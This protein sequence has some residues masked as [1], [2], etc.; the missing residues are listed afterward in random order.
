MSLARIVGGALLGAA[1]CVAA[2]ARP[3]P[4]GAAEGL[5]QV[6][7]AQ[8]ISATAGGFQQSLAEGS[9]FGWAVDALGDFDGDGAVEIA[10]GAHFAPETAP[11]TGSLWLLELRADGTVG[12]AEKI[13][14]RSPEF[15]GPITQDD[16][17]GISLAALGD[18]DGD[19]GVELAVGAPGDDDGG[20]NAGAIYIL[21]FNEAGELH[22]RSKISPR[23]LWARQAPWRWLLPRGLQ[24][25]F[26]GA[27]MPGDFFGASLEALG[28]L[29]GDGVGDLAVGTWNDNPEDRRR[30]EV[31]I[32]FLRADGSVKRHVEIGHQQGGFDGFLNPNDVF[33][34]SLANLGDID[35]DGVVDLAVGAPGD[36][37][38]CNT[39]GAVWIL[40][41]ERSGRVRAT[42]KISLRHGGFRGRLNNRSEMGVA[43]TALPAV[44][45]D[46]RVHLAV[47]ARG[48]SEVA[49]NMGAIWLLALES[50]GTV[51]DATKITGGT[52]G[53]PD[54]LEANDIFGVGLTSPGDLDG[55]GWPELVA[56]AEGDDD[57]A[58]RAG[59]AWVLFLE[60]AAR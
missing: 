48:D 44:A 39:C 41:L 14:E 50:D 20:A 19:G 24:G 15:S 40:F 16:V 10:V 60:P 59:A 28:D 49:A 1:C 2:G 7:S 30:G 35:G 58:D 26:D 17:F 32:L 22:G 55:D 54:E 29:D 21:S 3:Q 18:L 57:G 5:F 52:N 31:W 11:R 46:R 37:D 8:K 9:S 13:S 36:D 47:A 34:I 42:Q 27:V 23:P 4:A 56:G 53:M 25:G 33:G 12:A 43:L 45:G 6:R 51:S 38:G